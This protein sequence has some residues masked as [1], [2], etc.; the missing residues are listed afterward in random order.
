MSAPSGTR[1]HGRSDW[2]W[3]PANRVD[4]GGTMKSLLRKLGWLIRRGDR[5]RE[6]EAELQF[7]L[8]EEAEQH[9][10]EGLPEAE[11]RAAAR[12][13]LG[14]IALVQE[15]TRAAWGWILVEQ[16]SQDLRYAWR[17]I[18]ANPLF[19]VLAIV[20]VA[21]GIGASTSVY[22]FVDAV[23]LRSL[24][25]EHPKSLVVLNWKMKI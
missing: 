1:C 13:N 19:T 2:S 16:L 8:D 11:A 3:T 17:M 20:S 7:H 12:R 9:R 4:Q 10:H 25:V 22:S 6:L 5:E 15:N 21:L 23:L 18:V 24:P 14:N